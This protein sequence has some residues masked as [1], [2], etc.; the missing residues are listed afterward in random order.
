MTDS[1]ANNDDQ[2]SLRKIL[3][4]WA[5]VA[6]PMP[7]LA[8]WIAPA[9]AARTTINPLLL[10]WYLMIAGMIWQFV[11]SV[12]LLYQDLNSFTWSAICERIWLKQP[13]DPKTG[14]TSLKLFWWLIPAFMFYAA[15]EL[16]PVV[17]V[18][19]RLI[20]IP[21]P[22]LESLPDLDLSD[23]MQEEFVGAWWLMGVAVISCVFNYLLGEELLFRGVLLPKMHG[24][25]GKWDWVANSA[26]FA[27]YH[28]HRPL[29]MLGF[30]FGGFAWSLPSRY[31]RSIWFAIILHGLEAIPLLL[32]VFAVV[33]G[34]AF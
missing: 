12:W 10:I 6:I 28:M 30:I 3:A 5:V 20:L 32:G 8:F 29:Q 33:S 2:Y 24:V 14:K 9:V 16:T 1:H 23:L 17:D 21:L 19:G 11:V 13:S 15:I 27:L 18:I 25:F 4:I 34:R 31:Y 22:M 7:I 26:L